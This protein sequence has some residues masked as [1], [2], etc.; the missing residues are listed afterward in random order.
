MLNIDETPTPPQ[1]LTGKRPPGG[2]RRRMLSAK[3]LRLCLP[4]FMC[5]RLSSVKLL[6]AHA[7]QIAVQSAVRLLTV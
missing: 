2:Q 4:A 1:Q 6:S 7:A 5:R 3:L